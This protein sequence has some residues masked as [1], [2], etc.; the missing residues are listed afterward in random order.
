MLPGREA[1]IR[2]LLVGALAPDEYEKLMNQGYRKFGVVLF[3]P[4]CGACQE[5]RPIRV[6]AEKFAPSRSQRRAWRDNADLEV[7]FAE[8]RADLERLGL[9]HRYHDWQGRR[10][11]WPV[12]PLET[13]EYELQ[14]VLNPLPSIEVSVWDRDKLVGIALTDVTP[15]V[16]SGVYHFYDPEYSDRGLGTFL[17]LYVVELA[18]RLQKKWAYFG[19][20]VAGCADMAYKAKFR[21]CEV[22]SVAGEWQNFDA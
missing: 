13:K 19:F 7:R 4:E 3:R 16:V 8:P 10:K 15:N 12:N 22:L 17:V 18:R 1:R 14:F 6:D 9:Y 5:C 21:P 11:G 20:Y 2:S